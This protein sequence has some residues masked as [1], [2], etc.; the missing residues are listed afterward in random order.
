MIGKVGKNIVVGLIVLVGGLLSLA[1]LTVT[2][3]ADDRARV[4]EIDT[5]GHHVSATLG[6]SK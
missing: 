5:K 6:A 2:W 1:I 4:A 3:K